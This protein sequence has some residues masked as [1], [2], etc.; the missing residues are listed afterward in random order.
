MA[1]KRIKKC[2]YFEFL[3]TEVQ[4]SKDFDLGEKNVLAVLCFEYQAHSNYA[5]EHNGWFYKDAKTMAEEA[6]FE[7][8]Q[9]QRIIVKL[10]LKGAVRKKS[11]TNHKCNHYKINPKIVELIPNRQVLDWDDSDEFEEN[12]V[13]LVID[14]NSL[15]KTSRVLDETS[16]LSYNKVQAKV[17]DY[18]SELPF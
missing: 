13:A 15:D 10:E 11:G 14:K 7:E 12:N 17:V 4:E 1:N 6:E 16:V 5:K 2:G 18:S 8:R 3:P 9:F